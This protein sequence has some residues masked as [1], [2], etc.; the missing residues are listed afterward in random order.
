MLPNRS[1][2]NFFT[3]AIQKVEKKIYHFP[4]NNEGPRRTY[5]RDEDEVPNPNSNAHLWN[6]NTHNV[7]KRNEDLF[8]ESLLNQAY[9]NGWNAV[10]DTRTRVDSAYG[11][12]PTPTIQDVEED[13][14]WSMIVHPDDNYPLDQLTSTISDAISELP[15]S[16]LVLALKSLDEPTWENKQV[17]MMLWTRD[18]TD[19]IGTW[20]EV[21][22]GQKGHLI[23]LPP[24]PPKNCRRMMTIKASLL[25]S[26][27]TLCV[28]HARRR[29]TS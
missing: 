29:E 15:E 1:L 26:A 5:L 11:A 13:D 14:S 18:A 8:L 17:E 3:K 20:E 6:T 2:Q 21:T 7:Q 22:A 12:S 28:E 25:S 27:E 16:S 10:E 9:A 4:D 24:V 19:Q 23:H